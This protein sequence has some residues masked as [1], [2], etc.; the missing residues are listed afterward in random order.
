ME[1]PIIKKRSGE[2]TYAHNPADTFKDKSRVMH[3]LSLCLDSKDLESFIE[4][5]DAYLDVN[6]IYFSGMGALVLPKM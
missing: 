5:L 2:K 3:A 1:I 6:G 4:I